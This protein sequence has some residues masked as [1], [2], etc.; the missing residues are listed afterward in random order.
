MTPG[1]AESKQLVAR[2]GD[3]IR[4]MVH[5]NWRFRPQY[6]QAAQWLAQGKIGAIREFHLSTRSSGLVTRTTNGQ[7]F[8]LE[9]QPFLATLKR[10]IINELLIHHLDTVRFLVGSLRVVSANA[11]RACPEVIGED[12]AHITLK[13][14]CG[15]MGTVA[16]NFCEAGFPSLPT[17]RLELFGEKASIIFD[18]NVLT[19]IGD[20]E[21]SISLDL[22]EAYQKSYDNAIA[23]FFDC[24]E[25]GEP[26]ETDRLDNLKSL[27]LVSDAYD[28]AKL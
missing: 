12:K 13:A 25:S 1:L 11:A 16:G 18:N 17:D 28:L 9:R 5:E 7:L 24:L 19:L 23:H 2:V 14:D 10:L 21:K 8:A 3:R 4:F 26:F 22:E 27:Q 6:R 15:A 20:E